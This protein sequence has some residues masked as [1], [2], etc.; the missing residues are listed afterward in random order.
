MYGLVELFWLSCF[1]AEK[2]GWNFT[3]PLICI[4]NQRSIKNKEL[5]NVTYSLAVTDIWSLKSS[6]TREAHDRGNK[7]CDEPF[8]AE[9]VW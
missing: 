6:R 8:N 3:T 4:L 7:G 1:K 5:Y 2:S 9:K